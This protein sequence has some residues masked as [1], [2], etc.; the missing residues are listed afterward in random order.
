MK[1][2]TDRNKIEKALKNMNIAMNQL[3][4][5]SEDSGSIDSSTAFLY[6]AIRQIE[7]LK[8]LSSWKTN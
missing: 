7:N 1:T 5:V 2:K 8:T 3:E 6:N 4:S